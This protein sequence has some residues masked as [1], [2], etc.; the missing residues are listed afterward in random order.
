MSRIPTVRFRTRG[1]PWLPSATVT[2]ASSS[3]THSSVS[4][5]GRAWGGISSLPPAPPQQPHG[6][7]PALRITCRAAGPGTRSRLPPQLCRF[8]ESIHCWKPLQERNGKPSLP[9]P[10][11][12]TQGPGQGH[13][14]VPGPG[15]CHTSGGVMHCLAGGAD[16]IRPEPALSSSTG[17]SSSRALLRPCQLLCNSQTHRPPRDQTGPGQS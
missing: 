8:P 12:K 9:G 15:Q 2:T 13:F 4:V 14:Q 3:A 6:A 7:A 17:A 1:S 10:S 11:P 16:A 5:R